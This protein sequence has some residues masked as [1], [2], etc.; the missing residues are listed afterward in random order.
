MTDIAPVPTAAFNEA[1]IAKALTEARGDLFITAQSLKVTVRA[2]DRAIRASQDLQNTFLAIQ[3]VKATREYDEI[4]TEM[5][6]AEIARRLTVYRADALEALHELATAQ[7]PDAG[8]AQVKLAAASRL[9][10]A[11]GDPK[12]G[13]EMQDTLR[14]LNEKYHQEAPRIR[15]M[16]ETIEI[17][18]NNPPAI[19]GQP[20]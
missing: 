17:I 2:I 16:R 3:Q 12:G 20:S 6:E 15:V 5:L 4:T 19:E 13:G 1:S 9:I 10:G 7:A 18:P 14:L 11:V 8:Y